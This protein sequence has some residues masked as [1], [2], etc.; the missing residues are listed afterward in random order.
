M[1]GGTLRLWERAGPGVI[2]NGLEACHTYGA[3]IDHAQA[4]RC[5]TLLILGERDI[6]TPVR[7]GRELA[8]KIEISN[9][10]RKGQCAQFD[11]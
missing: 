2:H 11:D 7:Y 1:V 10:D 8:A 9:H 3:G 4:V 6:M 5:R